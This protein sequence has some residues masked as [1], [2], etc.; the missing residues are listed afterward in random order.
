MLEE[1]FEVVERNGIKGQ[2]EQEE[3]V[4]LRRQK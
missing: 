4:D 2:K 3:N 1:G